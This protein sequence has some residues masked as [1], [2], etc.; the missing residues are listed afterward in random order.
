MYCATCKIE[1]RETY[2]RCAECGAELVASPEP[3]REPLLRGFDGQ[4]PAVLWR[5][6]DPVAFSAILSAL[7]DSGIP[8][9]EANRRDFTASLSRPLALGYYGL[10][11]WQIFVHS[12]N[13]AQARRILQAALRPQPSIEHDASS[14]ET[15]VGTEQNSSHGHDVPEKSAAT[16]VAIWHGDDSER[17]EA[18]RE[19][20]LD[21]AIPCWES[22]GVAG[23]IHLYV[24][25]EFQARARALIEP[26]LQRAQSA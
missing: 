14:T 21:N 19:V 24:P 25:A 12:E 17:G 16:P 15:G 9:F 5:G 3:D 20:L 23:T 13:L 2:T 11:Y 18:L 4:P 26:E 22:A 1:Y 6:Q 10:P 8:F 7:A